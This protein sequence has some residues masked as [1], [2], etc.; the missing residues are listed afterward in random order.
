M[1]LCYNTSE[2][3]EGRIAVDWEKERTIRRITGVL[4]NCS[5]CFVK[6]LMVELYEY[7]RKQEHSK[8]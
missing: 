3:I 6:S 7:V 5:P 2:T 4:K 8:S 1:K